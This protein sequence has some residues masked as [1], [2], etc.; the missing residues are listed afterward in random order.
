M[1][2]LR[3]LMLFAGALGSVAVALAIAT[4]RDPDLW[5]FPDQ[6]ADR[7]MRGGKFVEAAKEY[8]DPERRGV[9]L[10]RA[11]NFK[12]AA[13]AFA[14]AATPEAMFDRGN[15]QVMLGKYAD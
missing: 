12:D 15:A 13:A 8:R 14:S 1:T 4:G 9:A 5:S 7:L 6:R 3:W 2:A 10:F 11:G